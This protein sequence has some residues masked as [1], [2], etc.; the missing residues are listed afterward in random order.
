MATID[1]GDHHASRALSLSRLS[2][3]FVF[4]QIQKF[5]SAT[6]LFSVFTVDP[7]PPSLSLSLIAVFHTRSPPIP[8]SQICKAPT[9]GSKERSRCGAERLRSKKKRVAI[10]ERSGLRSMNE[11]GC[12]R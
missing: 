3:G 7:P 2:Y 6:N 4:Q 9:A 12:D 5:Y 11:A 8:S 1:V 10:D